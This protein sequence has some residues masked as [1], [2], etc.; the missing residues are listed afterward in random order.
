[1]DSDAEPLVPVVAKSVKAKRR[2]R[3]LRLRRDGGHKP[4]AKPVLTIK[5]SRNR[6]AEPV[7]E[8]MA[9]GPAVATKKMPE[10]ELER[11]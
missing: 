7:E 10:R 5:R 3:F 1:M 11:Q 9:E 2:T 8:A 4:V 6:V